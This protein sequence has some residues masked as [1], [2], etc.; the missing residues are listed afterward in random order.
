MAGESSAHVLRL[1][2]YFMHQDMTEPQKVWGCS[3]SGTSPPD[4]FKPDLSGHGVE[5]AEN[6]P[7][8][9]QA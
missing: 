5:E 9:T 8:L 1:L 6:S 2:C 7:S 3:T 4:Q